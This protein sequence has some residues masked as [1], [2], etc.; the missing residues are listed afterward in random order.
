M[1]RNEMIKWLSENTTR[2]QWVSSTNPLFFKGVQPYPEYWGTHPVLF[3]DEYF[4]CNNETKETIHIN[5]VFEPVTEQPV[6]I[7]GAVYD[8]GL[9]NKEPQQF[10]YNCKLNM[11]ERGTNESIGASSIHD[12]SVVTHF[13]LVSEPERITDREAIDTI[14][15]E[16]AAEFMNS[17]SVTSEP[18]DLLN[19]ARGGPI[20]Q[21]H[22][23]SFANFGN[24][25]RPH[26]SVLDKQEGGSHYKG[27]G[28]Q[29]WEIIESNDMGFFDGNAL[30]YLMRHR[31]KNGAE[32]IKKA[33]HYLE[34]IL[35]FE[36]DVRR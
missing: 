6:Y 16:E 8:I 13:K 22:L 35:E 7:D 23:E 30:K 25:G 3:T 33:I 31:D 4:V 9:M 24:G 17:S 27:K 5:D 14:R 1:N 36:Y 12:S 20:S 15:R 29:P 2:E 21:Q 18:Q 10:V 32:D 26:T 28:V 34:A 11:F 19:H